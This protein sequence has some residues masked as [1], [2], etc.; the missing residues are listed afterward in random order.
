[1]PGALWTAHEWLCEVFLAEVYQLTGWTGLVVA[2]A[3]A[4]ALTLSYVMRFLL[5]RMEPIH[6]LVFSVLTASMLEPQL[7]ARPHVFSWPLLAIWVGALTSAVELRR[8]PPWWLLGIIVLW[9]NLH[10]SFTLGLALGA[11][12][13]IEAVITTPISERIAV[14]RPWGLFVALS[15]VAAL[16]TP[17]GWNGLWYSI[18]VMKLSITLDVISEWLS[19]D[20]HR[21]QPLEVWLLLILSIA[22]SGRARLS[23][24]RLLLVAGLVHLALK[25][26]RY[27]TTLGL[28]APILM[29]A[30]LARAWYVKQ[31]GA[32]DAR[33]LDKFFLTLA[34][35]AHQTAI[36][37][38]ALFT[39]MI[40]AS[41]A[42]YRE[43]LPSHA[44]TPERAVQAALQAGAKDNVLNDYAFGGYL[45]FRRI[46]VFIDGRA[47]VYGDA[48]MQ[49][50]LA[51]LLLKN[52]ADLAAMLDRYKVGWT[53]LQT[54]TPA[55]ALLD[56]MPG[57]HRVYSDEIAIVH[58]RDLGSATTAK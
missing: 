8:G 11:A 32:H 15:I 36:Y 14:A 9:A 13:A 54:G 38:A 18:Y 2:A 6:A 28:V 56:L 47:E 19:P 31:S 44:I 46:P 3:L 30:S 37:V 17:S 57:W 22:L 7:L 1:M 23:I 33:C 58:M 25:H 53:L 43:Y 41:G 50:M 29:A 5:A 10:G 55:A 51:G 35:P 20:F 45:I 16:I 26:Q 42:Y 48:F 21:Y 27:V 39:A 12:L 4:F 49:K 40:I 24:I 52:P 34:R